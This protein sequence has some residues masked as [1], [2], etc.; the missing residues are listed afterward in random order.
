MY[1]FDKIPSTFIN[2]IW[3]LKVKT[4]DLVVRFIPVIGFERGLPDKKFV[5]QDSETPQINL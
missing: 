5:S 1:L 3:K 4:F 2:P